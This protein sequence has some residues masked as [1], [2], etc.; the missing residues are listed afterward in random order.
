MY[1]VVLVDRSTGSGYAYVAPT[2]GP[3]LLAATNRRTATDLLWETLAAS[4]PDEP[5]TV[6]TIS[7]ANEWAIDVG[8]A[9]RMEVHTHNYLALRG[10][11]PPS[12]YLPNGHFL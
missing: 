7:A 1:R 9:A 3:V 12:P 8:M 11:R 5:C 10:M 6:G 2:G 4:T